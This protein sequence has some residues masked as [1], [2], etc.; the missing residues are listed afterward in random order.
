MR[1][2]IQTLWW[3]HSGGI[4]SFTFD[5]NGKLYTIYAENDKVRDITDKYIDM[6]MNGDSARSIE[7]ELWSSLEKYAVEIPKEIGTDF[8]LKLW[9]YMKS[10]FKI[11]RS[12]GKKY[13][14]GGGKKKGK[15]SSGS[16]F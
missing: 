16:G 7:A 8:G 11:I 14:E 6:R 12:V 10:P 1:C 9:N 5:K 15:F 4:V 2:T 3:W 13:K